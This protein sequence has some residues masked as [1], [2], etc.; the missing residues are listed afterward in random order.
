[1]GHVRP[2]SDFFVTVAETGARK[3]ASDTEATWPIRKREQALRETRMQNCYYVNDKTAWEKA[4]DDAVK[5][6]KA[7]E[8]HKGRPDGSDR[9]LRRRSNRCCAPADLEGLCK[10]PSVN[11]VWVFSLLRVAIR[12]R[13]RD[14]RRCKASYR[15]RHV[16]IVG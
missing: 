15:G 13:A 12:R 3:S 8:P 4:R 7:I 5:R 2:P 16:E 11:R 1:M 9:R 14:V 6:G 10:L